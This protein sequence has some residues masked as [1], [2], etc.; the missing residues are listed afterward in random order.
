MRS[1]LEDFGKVTVVDAL[2][3]ARS[4]PLTI[5]GGW[6]LK[7]YAIQH[8]RFERALFIDADNLPVLPMGDSDNIEVGEWVLAVGS[9]FGLSGTVT[10]G[11]VSAKGR[12]S[13]G[14]AD[15]ENFLQTDAAINPGNSGGPL[16]NLDGEVI[17]VNTAIFSRSGGFNGIGFAI[18]IN[19]ARH[20]C[21]QLIE[22]G[23]VTRGYL[24]IAI[25]QLTPELV[26]SFQLEDSFGVLVSDVAKDSPAAQSG[27][28]SGDV[29]VQFE[30]DPVEELGR[31]RNRVA[32]MEP[33]STVNLTVLRHSERVQLQLT[34]GSMPGREAQSHTSDDIEA[35]GLIV[36]PL[37]DMVRERYNLDGEAGVLVSKV[38]AG[39][40]AAAAGIRA[41][42]LILE[43][44]RTAVRDLD[45]FHQLVEKGSQGNNILLLV[46][47]G[48][49]SRY[50]ALPWS[51]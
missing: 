31:F 12:S 34:I 16:V 8:S 21:E 24:G 5:V 6:E 22:N 7:P 33:G 1:L 32:R 29:I 44:N 27:L 15:Y 23:S 49:F 47:T 17:G 39:S 28:K 18:P 48:K 35:L 41:G 13:I 9:P 14:I 19:M 25:Q 43:V 2:E 40:P 11:I 42:S 45:H 10:S 20:V 51:S 4:Y 26:S 30:G 46:K 3:V 50:L 38:A 37:T 36:R